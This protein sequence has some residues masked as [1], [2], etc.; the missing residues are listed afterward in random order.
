MR[1]IGTFTAKVDASARTIRKKDINICI[2]EETQLCDA[3]SYDIEPEHGN[4][5]CKLL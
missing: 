1:K 2:Q 3:K 4:H 5:G